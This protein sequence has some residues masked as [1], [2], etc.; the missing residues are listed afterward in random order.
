MKTIFTNLGGFLSRNLR[1][2]FSRFGET[3]RYGL[4]S[5]V[6][7]SSLSSLTR[8]QS[9]TLFAMNRALDRLSGRVAILRH[10]VSPYRLPERTTA[11]WQNERVRNGRRSKLK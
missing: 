6:H 5:A 7:F 2:L 10:C 4:L 1:S 8:T 11:Q 3:D 9:A